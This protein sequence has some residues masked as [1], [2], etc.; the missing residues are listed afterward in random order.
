[1]NVEQ[2]SPDLAFESLK[3]ERAAHLVDVRTQ[4]EWTF[5]GVPDLSQLGKDV[6]CIEWRG[7]PSMDVNH[8]FADTLLAD[9]D[10]QEVSKLLFIC[11][12]GVRSFEA[13]SLMSEVFKQNGQI[14]TCL[15][16]SEGFEGDLSSH[17]HRG[18]N[19]GWKARD[20]PWR[21]S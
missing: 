21:Q 16:V 19:N 15:N 9:L 7:S 12:S 17:D 20:L 14:V 2:V 11:R 1:M 4:G 3:T 18:E 6:F 13:A 10:G 5:V 8:A